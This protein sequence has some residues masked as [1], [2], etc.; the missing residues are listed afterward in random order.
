[1]VHVFGRTSIRLRGAA[2]SRQ[3][4]SHDDDPRHPTRLH[5]DL[6]QERLRMNRQVPDAAIRV[7]LISLQFFFSNLTYEDALGFERSE[8]LARDWIGCDKHRPKL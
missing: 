1:L 7:Y 3:R 5:H 8:E 6:F 4:R 2:I